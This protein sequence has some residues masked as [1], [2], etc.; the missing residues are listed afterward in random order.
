MFFVIVTTGPDGTPGAWGTP[1]GGPY[2]SQERAQQ[3]AD[4][5]HEPASS[6]YVEATMIMVVPISSIGD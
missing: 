3:V 5:M 2:R 1:G 6:F 4:L